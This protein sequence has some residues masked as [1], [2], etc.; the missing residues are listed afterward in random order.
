METF[1]EPRDLVSNPGFADQKQAALSG[2]KDGMI[3][4]PIVGI[5]RGFNDLPF[6][7]TLQCCYGHFVYE[8]QRDPHNLDPLPK[9]GRI[10]RIEYRIAYLACCIDNSEAGRDLFQK[11]QNITRL[12]PENIQF[13]S[14]RWFWKRQVNSYALQVEPDRFKH[15]DRA[16]LGH[17]EALYIERLRTA[18][19]RNLEGLLGLL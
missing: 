17:P 6:C 1:V 10:S 4:E 9:S 11:L 19:F 7:Y 16:I 5:I 12:D 2:L 3:D 13:C 14:A 18:F 15:K 8:G